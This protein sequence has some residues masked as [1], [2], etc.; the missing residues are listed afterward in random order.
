MFFHFKCILIMI[1]RGVVC[2]RFKLMAFYQARSDLRLLNAGSL[3]VKL[4]LFMR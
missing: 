2:F 1:F 4:L 3:G